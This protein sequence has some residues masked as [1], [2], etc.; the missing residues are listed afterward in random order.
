MNGQIDWAALPAIVALLRI[1]NAERLLYQLFA[2]RDHLNQ[3]N[4]NE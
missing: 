2:I 1:D 3:Q 4:A